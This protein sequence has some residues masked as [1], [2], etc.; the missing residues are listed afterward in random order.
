MESAKKT[1]QHIQARQQNTQDVD[2]I[3][4]GDQDYSLWTSKAFTP[5]VNVE[6]DANAEEEDSLK[7]EEQGPNEVSYSITHSISDEL[8][9]FSDSP[10]I[11][12]FG[13][14]SRKGITSMRNKPSQ[15]QA[16]IDDQAHVSPVVS[17]SKQ[18]SRPAPS[19]P[20]AF[21]QQT[22]GTF[23]A[24][25]PVALGVNAEIGYVAV[26][27]PNPENNF[28]PGQ[29]I[30]MDHQNF[31]NNMFNPPITSP[32]HHQ[33]SA[34]VNQN[35]AISGNNHGGGSFSSTDTQPSQEALRQ[36]SERMKQEL[37]V[38]QKKISCLNTQRMNNSSN[39][40]GN[41]NF[42]ADD[43]SANQNNDVICSTAGSTVAQNETKQ[44][45][46]ELQLIENTI[47]DREREM[48]QIRQPNMAGEG[49]ANVEY[50]SYVA[51]G[52]I[53]DGEE[54]N[55]R[56]QSITTTAMSGQMTRMNGNSFDPI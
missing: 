10:Q 50:G 41:F 54:V 29:E 11:S 49:E 55:G 12:R 32:S 36:E 48:I 53:T 19:L 13:P 45:A 52:L 14:I 5:F 24:L 25:Q 40:G 3:L 18:M 15:S 8:I 44:L 1:S 30:A 37:E 46:T 34:M 28:V 42:V 33:S 31:L 23:M 47:K 39:G 6:N 51:Q 26:Q 2:S 22:N 20:T 56:A 21:L 38:L 16:I 9:P 17:N 7:S 27:Q 35:Y 4:T 43:R